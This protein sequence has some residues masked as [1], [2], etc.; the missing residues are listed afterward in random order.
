MLFSTVSVVHAF[1]KD[2]AF[3]VIRC[4]AVKDIL[5]VIFIFDCI[6]INWHKNCSSIVESPIKVEEFICS[7]KVI[8]FTRQQIYFA[9]LI[10]GIWRQLNGS[11]YLPY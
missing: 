5:L 7:G 1:I 9:W 2:I 11:I 4:V 3:K 10:L 8:N 6:F